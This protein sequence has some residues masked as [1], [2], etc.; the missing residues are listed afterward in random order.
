MCNAGALEV[1]KNDMFQASRG[2]RPDRQ[3]IAVLLTDGRSTDEQQTWQRAMEV[4]QAD[5]TLLVV[6]ISAH[7]YPREL[8]AI[9]SSPVDN[10]VFLTD[11]FTTLTDVKDALTRALCNGKPKLVSH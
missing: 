6:G 3:N 2:D 5:I 10:N 4:R 11:S 7:V 1:I 8:Q 9:A